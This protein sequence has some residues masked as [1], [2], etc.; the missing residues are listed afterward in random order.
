MKNGIRSNRWCRLPNL[1]RAN[2]D[3]R[4]RSLAAIS[5]TPSFT[6]FARAAPGDCCQ[7]ILAL[8]K[9][10]MATSVFGAGLDLEVHSRSAWGLVGE[11]RRPER[12]AERTAHLPV[13]GT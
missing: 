8:G 12:C 6:W 13:I 10:S 5:S 1:E 2:A 7:K 9:P 4:F 3:D 11:E